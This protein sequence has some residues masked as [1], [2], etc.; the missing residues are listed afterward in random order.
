MIQ[1]PAQSERTQQE[2]AIEE[3]EK[4]LVTLRTNPSIIKVWKLRLLCWQ[5]TS[6]FP[7]SLFSLGKRTY[8][9]TKEQPFVD[10][11]NFLMGRLSL[12]WKDAQQEW[13]VM[14]STK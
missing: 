6:Q 1:C 8:Q 4:N 5:D 10:W 13:I 12:K 11:T 9:T 7:F 14:I 2:L 3:L